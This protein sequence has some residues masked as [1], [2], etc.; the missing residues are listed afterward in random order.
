MT[1]IL[2][3]RE[4]EV[5]TRVKSTADASAYRIE[6]KSLIVLQFNCSSFYNKALEIRSL[7]DKYNPHV[8]IGIESWLKEVTGNAEVFSDNF[9]T[10]R[11][12]RPACGGW[13]FICVKNIIAAYVVMGR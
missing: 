11:R 9:T 12:D 13:N 5:R 1:N 8:I 7:V 6:V 3:R 10:F 4:V 2:M